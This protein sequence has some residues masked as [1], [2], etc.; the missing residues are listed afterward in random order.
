MWLFFEYKFRFSGLLEKLETTFL[1][2]ESFGLQVIL[3][4]DAKVIPLLLHNISFYNLKAHTPI[5]GL[6]ATSIRYDSWNN[7]IATYFEMWLHF[8]EPCMKQFC[9]LFFLYD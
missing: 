9:S 1:S 8:M 4:N 6:S 2:A 3:F 5:C 7:K